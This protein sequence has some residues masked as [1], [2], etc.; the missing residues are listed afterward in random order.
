MDFYVTAAQ[1]IPVLYLAMLFESRFLTRRP[2]SY[3]GRDDDPGQWNATQAIG[4]AAVVL[5]MG[6]GEIAALLGVW[7]RIT[8]PIVDA[9]V[10]LALLSGLLGVILPPLAKQV[11]FLR[12]YRNAGGEWQ[13]PT[14]MAVGLLA[15]LIGPLSWLVSLAP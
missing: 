15:V 6:M 4:R 12:E 11:M 9:F 8:L 5:L 3:F 13:M 10:V 7:Q 1:I 2:D 14:L